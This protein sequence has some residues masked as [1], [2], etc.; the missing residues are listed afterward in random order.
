MIAP[1][2]LKMK[3]VVCHSW[4]HQCRNVN[5]DFTSSFG[6][7]SIDLSNIPMNK[8]IEFHV[9]CTKVLPLSLAS[10]VNCDSY[11]VCMGT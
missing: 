7:G 1:H 5:A 9:E 4:L 11:E 8:N 6:H 10:L 3:F 2:T